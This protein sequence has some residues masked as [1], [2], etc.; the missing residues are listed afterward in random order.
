MTVGVIGDLHLIDEASTAQHACLEWAVERLSKKKVD[1]LVVLGDITA[2]GTPGAADSF[3]K[4]INRLNTPKLV[5]LG[6]SDVRSPQHS[7]EIEKLKSG[8]VI[9][10]NGFVF[11]GL[12]TEHSI[13]EQHE[14]EAIAN[15]PNDQPVLIFLHHNIE[16]LNSESR[17]WLLRWVDEHTVS[18][19]VTGHLH[20]C[21]E[22]KL[23]N[24]NIVT[25]RGLDPDKAIGGAPAIE[26]FR[27]QEGKWIKEI[28][29]YQS[30]ILEGWSSIDRDK[31]IHMLGLSCFN[32]I[33]GI[34]FAI[35]NNIQCLEFRPE[36]SALDLRDLVSKWRKTGDTIL[37]I[38]LPEL[39]W[40]QEL[41]Q[42]EGVTVCKKVIEW[43]FE[44]GAQMFTIHVPNVPVGQMTNETITWKRFSDAFYDLFHSCIQ[45]VKIQIENMHMTREE[46]DDNYRRFG[47]I[48]DEC[49]QWVNE[50]NY[51]LNTNHF[52][53]LLDIGH[54]RNNAPYS[55]KYPLS[56]W[57][58]LTGNLTGGYHLH[59]VVMSNGVM[60]N[61]KPFYGL[62]GPLISLG[63]FIWAWKQQ[64]IN[65]API[66]LEIRDST[67]SYE[68]YTRL[69]E[70]ICG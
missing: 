43:A 47:Y 41:Q 20:K 64:V 1:L 11:I 8:N 3:Q 49:I 23:K 28:E 59:Q 6:N 46:I 19:I 32:P 15:I 17:D 52:K 38:H 22:Y 30:S 24:T 33:Q 9:K 5:V 18:L 54:A 42:V 29:L 21:I 13:I 27:Y 36:A 65:H 26:Y 2:H 37:S 60:E 39:K 44:L 48:P 34:E 62:Y 55:E 40:N 7:S 67:E 14:R 69:K 61:H 16:A 63:G 58:H 53:I 35:N 68:C 31:L 25:I 66:F 56:A 4:C 70:I 45:N 51:R 10:C 12:N 50:L 57:Y